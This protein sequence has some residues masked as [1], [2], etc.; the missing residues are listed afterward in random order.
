MNT[1]NP[2]DQIVIIQLVQKAPGVSAFYTPGTKLLVKDVSSKFLETFK[3]SYRVEKA[4]L[5]LS[6][7]KVKTSDSKSEK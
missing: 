3:S 4:T 1:L 2:E 6:K 5:K 7:P